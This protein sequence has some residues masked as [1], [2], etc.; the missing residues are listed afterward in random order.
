MKELEGLGGGLGGTEEM[1]G[2]SKMELGSEEGVRVRG[3]VGVLRILGESGNC[4]SG[5]T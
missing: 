3:C 1:T 5:Q 4:G 2:A